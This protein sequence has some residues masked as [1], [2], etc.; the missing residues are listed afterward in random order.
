MFFFLRITIGKD[1]KASVLHCYLYNELS[2]QYYFKRNT[3]LII[4]FRPQKK[5][6]LSRHFVLIDVPV[7]GQESKRSCIDFV[8]F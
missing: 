7:R 4:T 3:P 1:Y 5:L 2:E 8:S 6:I